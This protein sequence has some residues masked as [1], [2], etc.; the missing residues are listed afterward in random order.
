[1]G[2]RRRFQRL[3]SFISR[4]MNSFLVLWFIFYVFAFQY[5]WPIPI[6]L[7]S[8]SFWWFVICMFAFPSVI[9]F[10]SNISDDSA[11]N[12]KQLTNIQ[13]I[14]GLTINLTGIIALITIICILFSTPM[15]HAKSYSNLITIS[16]GDEEVDIPDIETDTM[17]IVDMKAAEKLGDRQLSN[18]QNPMYYEVDD[19]YNLMNINGDFYRISPLNYGGTFISHIFKTIKAGSIPAYIQVDATTAGNAKSAKAVN[20][21]EPMVYSPSAIFNHKLERYLHLIYPTYIFGKSFFELDDDLNP[22]WITPVKTP[23]IGIFGGSIEKS[24][25]VVNAVTGECTEFANSDIPEWIDHVHSVDYLFNL[26]DYH[27]KY[28][29][30]F[31]NYHFS[32]TNVYNTSYSIRSTEKDE[33]ESAFTPFDGYNWVIGTDGNIYAYSGITPDNEAETNIGFVLIDSRTADAKF[34][35]AAGADESSAQHAAEGLV[36]DLRYS[37]NFPTIVK[38]NGE[39]VYFMSLKDKAGMVQRYAICDVRN[40][41]NVVEAS[42]ISEAITKFT[43]GNISYTANIQSDFEQES[44]KEF[45]LTGTVAQVKEAEQGGNTYYFFMLE[46]DEYVYVSSIQNSSLQPFKLTEGASVTINC[47]DSREQGIRIVTNIKF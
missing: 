6:N 41:S 32:K 39:L 16:D 46:N 21:A 8:S 25:V 17:I 36:Q 34:F 24:V 37:A 45:E 42:T 26:V 3:A 2:H 12:N 1:M 18:V 28:Q 14:S 23:T 10:N 38:I 11:D 9:I 40:Y 20:L 30:G 29:N 15:L 7:R 27:Y 35:N 44:V 19:E 5:I 43:R 13:L 31:L 4:R 33:D 47:Y 22:Y